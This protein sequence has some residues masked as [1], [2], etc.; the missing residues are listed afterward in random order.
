MNIIIIAPRGKMGRLITKS[1]AAR[2]DMRIVAGIAPAGRDYCGRDIGLLAGLGE[3]VGAPVV[4]NLAAVIDGC[5]IIIDY[6]TVETSL[7]VAELAVKHRKAVVCGTTG[8]TPGQWERLREAARQIPFLY[9]ANT[10]RVINLLY[11]VLAMLAEKFADAADIEII[12]MH[13]RD[14]KD[15]PSGTSRELGHALAKGLGKP[16][17]D[18]AVFGRSGHSP[19]QPGTIGYHS[20]RAGDISSSHTVMFGFKAERLEITHHAHNWECFAEGAC[21]CARFLAGKPAGWY[22]VQDVLADA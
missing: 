17:D 18:I 2:G 10:S 16:F 13:D 22:T 4:D 11:G 7:A 19:R 15:A 12:E 6:S 5:D 8:F 9:G 1:V 3:E 20:V 14:K 21:N